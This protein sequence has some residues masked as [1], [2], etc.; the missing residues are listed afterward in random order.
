M[1]PIK[2]SLYHH[3][4]PTFIRP[5]SLCLGG[6]GGDSSV[7]H[8]KVAVYGKNDYFCRQ[9]AMHQRVQCG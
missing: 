2:I 9:N 6:W 5:I 7:F 1:C 8:A 4:T 3:S